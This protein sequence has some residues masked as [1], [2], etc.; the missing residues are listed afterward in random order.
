MFKSILSKNIYELSSKN[1][2][3]IYKNCLINNNN[4]NNCK[5]NMIQTE[6]IPNQKVLFDKVK[7][8]Q[9]KDII[10]CY[11]NQLPVNF[12]ENNGGTSLVNGIKNMNRQKW[13]EISNVIQLFSLGKAINLV[14]YSPGS[15]DVMTN[16]ELVKNLPESVPFCV[17]KNY[18]NN[19]EK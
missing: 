6:I 17:I 2:S 4:N 19:I 11:L 1:V 9:H 15:V 12:R 7:I 16:P 5:I 13:G 3:F 18:N 8:N 10:I 14:D